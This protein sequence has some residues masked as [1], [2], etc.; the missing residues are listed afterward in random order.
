MSYRR[1][2]I[3]AVCR[4][5]PAERPATQPCSARAGDTRGA[6][7]EAAQRTL[8]HLE[9]RLRPSPQW[10]RRGRDD[11]RVVALAVAVEAVVE[12]VARAGRVAALP[13]G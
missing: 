7:G 5:E 12:Q 8:R 4:F 2:A 1:A 3:D 6:D 11:R 13:D 9:V 10:A